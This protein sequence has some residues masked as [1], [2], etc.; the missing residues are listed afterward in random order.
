LTPNF[1]VLQIGPGADVTLDDLTIAH[2]MAT[3][4]PSLGGGI[5]N[6][7]GTLSIT[8]C[9]FTQNQAGFG[10]AIGNSANG[11]STSMSITNSTFRENSA[12]GEGGGIYHSGTG[13]TATLTITSCTFFLNR[14]FGGGGGIINHGRSGS[15]TLNVTRSTFNLNSGSG[16]LNLGIAVIT[17]ST[18]SQN[19]AQFET[20]RAIFNNGQFGSASLQIE[21]NILQVDSGTTLANDSGVVTSLGYNLSTDDGAGLLIA[22]GDQIT[23]DPMLDPVGLRNNGGPTDTVAILAGSPAID[24]GKDFTGTGLDQRGSVRPFDFA[25]IANAADGDGSDIGAVEVK[26]T[27]LDGDR[28]GVPDGVDACPN[29][30][31][32]ETVFVGTCDTGVPNHLFENGCTMADLIAAVAGQAKNH[33]AFVSGVARL[34]NDWKRQGIISGAEKGAIQS[35]AGKSKLP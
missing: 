25:D 3:E 31:L 1:R 10:G 9:I 7:H 12:G 19:S 24:K 15:A 16:I 20:G 5:L 29:S 27:E 23:T 32:S 35:C 11:G 22:T 33:G 18:F 21:S 26:D 2:G 6:D 28:D 34:T 8:N 13:G 17:N 14:G 4:P 30:D